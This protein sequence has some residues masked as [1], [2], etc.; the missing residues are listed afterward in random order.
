MEI[1]ELQTAAEAYYVH[2]ERKGKSLNTITSYRGSIKPFLAFA[3]QRGV[4]CFADM[5]RA[6]VEEYQDYLAINQ[7]L[8]T[9]KSLSLRSRSCHA[10]GIRTFFLWG[11]KVER[12]D[13]KLSLWLDQIKL[14]PLQPRPLTRKQTLKLKVYF[15]E[16]IGSPRYLRDR[17]MFFYFVGTA[18]RVAEAL[19]VP[20]NSWE[21]ATVIQKGGGSKTMICPAFSAE[22]MRTYLAVRIDLS[23]VLWVRRVGQTDVIPMNPASILRV[24][25]RLARQLGIP[26]FVTHQ[27]RHTAATALLASGVDSMTVTNFM[28]HKSPATLRIYADVPESQ[29]QL[30]AQTMSQVMAAG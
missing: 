3:A 9:G 10:S 15:L 20:R 6:L 7:T 2:L 19:R 16:E 30:A 29:R 8:L 25:T 22:M 5:T 14:P 28:G 23:P 1:Y 18:A 17:A 26:R 27:L 13:A 24:W 12:C 11:A 21:R 4:L